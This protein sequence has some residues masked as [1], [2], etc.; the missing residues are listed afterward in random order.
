MREEQGQ[1]FWF[2][3]THFVAFL[4]D[5]VVG[6]RRGDREKDLQSLVLRHQVR[7]LQRQRPRPPRVGCENLLPRRAMGYAA[8]RSYSWMSPPSTSRRLTA[9]DPAVGAEGIGVC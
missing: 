9:P 3:L 5:L 8:S 1:V 4:V 6:T 7:L 2:V